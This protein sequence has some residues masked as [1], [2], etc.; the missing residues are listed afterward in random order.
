[1]G[2]AVGVIFD[3]VSPRADRRH[4]L[5]VRLGSIANAKES[6]ACTGLVEQIKNTW[7]QVGIGAVVKRQRDDAFIRLGRWQPRDIGAKPPA[8]RKHSGGGNNSMVAC[9]RR[10]HQTP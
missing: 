10:Q 3:A 9:Q 5:R 7:G 6:R 2:V 1:M 4:Q 8:S